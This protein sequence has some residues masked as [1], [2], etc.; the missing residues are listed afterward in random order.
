MSGCWIAID[1]TESEEGAGYKC[2]V[3]SQILRMA[4]DCFGCVAAEWMNECYGELDQCLPRPW[5]VWPIMILCVF[6]YVDG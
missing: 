2:R 3:H 5:S 6:M 4:M 1:F